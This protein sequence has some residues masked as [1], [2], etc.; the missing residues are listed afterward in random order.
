MSYEINLEEKRNQDLLE[1]V[2]R[3]GD[4]VSSKIDGEHI[5]LLYRMDPF[6]I[7]M[8]YSM[9]DQKIDGMRIVYD[10]NMLN[11]G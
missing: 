10:M 4:L 7:E 2:K 3:D 5:V 6:L 1:L 9:G 8:E 11:E